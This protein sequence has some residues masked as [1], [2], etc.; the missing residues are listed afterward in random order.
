MLES[1]KKATFVMASL[2]TFSIGHVA[3]AGR[4]GG[5]L[6]SVMEVNGLPRIVLL[7]VCFS[8]L[9]GCGKNE[10]SLE[11]DVPRFKP[12]AAGVEALRLYDTDGDGFLSSQELSACP[13]IKRHL[14]LFDTD[15]DQQVSAEEIA[16]RVRQWLDDRGGLMPLRSVVNY[17]GRPLFGAQLEFEPEPFL[18]DGLKPAAGEVD[19]SGTAEI[20]LASADKPASFQDRKVVQPGLYKVRI[21][22]PKV[23]LPAKYN[24]ETQLGCEVSQQT[25][26]PYT[27][28]TF[29]L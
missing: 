29:N 27:P 16:A 11:V 12:K 15:A 10:R 6:G 13:G 22:H 9:S 25:A 17:K 5:S 2:S 4:V 24:V 28:L 21:T 20:S 23:S 19:E 14:D 18:G 3:V 7:A 1:S 8:L 26:Q